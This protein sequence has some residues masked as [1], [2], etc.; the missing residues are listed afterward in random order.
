MFVDRDLTGCC[1]NTDNCN[2]QGTT[3]NTTIP[4]QPP[5]DP[6]ACY[7]GIA[8]NGVTQTGSGLVDVNRPVSLLDF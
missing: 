4:I 7:S 1:C 2:T 8:I 6:I 5:E 3:I